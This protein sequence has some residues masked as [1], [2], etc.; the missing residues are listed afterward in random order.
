MPV[1][2]FFAD[3]AFN[4]KDISAMSMV[5][6]AVSSRLGLNGRSDEAMIKVVAETIIKL[7]DR[8]VH[9]AETLHKMTLLELNIVN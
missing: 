8:D 6:E 3:Q 5:F 9:D 7:V 4:Q 1:T 2:S